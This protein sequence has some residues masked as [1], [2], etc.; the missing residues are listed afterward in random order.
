MSGGP[1][2]SERFQRRVWLTDHAL[3]RSAERNIPVDMLLDVIETGTLRDQEG[4]HCWIWKAVEGR[5]DNL[6][7]VAVLL[8]EAVIVKTVLHH[9][10]LEAT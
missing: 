2:W 7:C 1:Y 8:A 3:A 5:D 4:G 10:E 9:F 6:L